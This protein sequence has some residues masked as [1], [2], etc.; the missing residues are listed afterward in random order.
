MRSTAALLIALLVGCE[1][2][3]PVDV[4]CTTD[5]QCDDGAFCNGDERCDPEADA[6]DEDGCVLAEAPCG[7]ALCSE[8]T[9]A[10]VADCPDNDGDG[11]AELSCGGDDCDDAN[12]DRAPGLPE[13]CDPDD[14]DE[15]CDPSTVGDTDL[16]RDG[17]ISRECCNG[18]LCGRDCDDADDQRHPSEAETCDGRDNDCDGLVDEGVV[19]VFYADDDGDDYG[20]LETMAACDRPEGFAAVAGDC[21]DEDDRRSPNAIEVCDDVDN[22]CDGLRDEGLLETFYRDADGDGV[23]LIGDTREACAPPSG[24][25]RL[26]G[27]CDDTTSAISPTIAD[28]CNGI[29][30][31]CDG[32][33]DGPGEDVDRDGVASIACGGNDCDDTSARRRPGLEETCDGVDNDCDGGIDEGLLTATYVDADGDGF[34]TDREDLCAVPAGRITVGGDCDDTRSTVHPM[35]AALCDGLDNDCDAGTPAGDDLDG[36]GEIAVGG[37][38]SGGPYAARPR[39][40]CDDTNA[41]RFAAAIEACN[42]IDDDCDAT[43][44]GAEGTSWCNA[45]G[46][47][48]NA[49]ATCTA[50]SCALACTG[51]FLDC[52]AGPGCESDPRTD[53][54]HCSGCGVACATGQYCSAS[55]CRPTRAFASPMPRPADF[56]RVHSA[57][58]I[59][60]AG[61]F[62]GSQNFGVPMTS[63]GGQ[64]IFVGS[65]TTAGAFRWGV[66]IG[67]AGNEAITGFEIDA[68]HNIYLAGRFEGSV[69]FGT[70]GTPIASAGGMDAFIAS[71]TSTG[72]A[73][74]AR[75]YGT[76]SN[77]YIQAMSITGDDA[78]ISLVTQGAINVHGT[79]VGAAA[80]TTHA[81][82]SLRPFAM[83]YG[84]HQ[85]ITVLPPSNY[86]A[87]VYVAPDRSAWVV[88]QW[89]DDLVIGPYTF[90]AL[91][92]GS[93]AF[94][95]RVDSGGVLGA[96]A[97]DN[98]VDQY[99]FHVSGVPDG[100]VVSGQFRSTGRFGGAPLSAVNN[101][102]G[103]IA[104]FRD[105]GAHVFSVSTPTCFGTRVEPSGDILAWG[106][107]AASGQH[108]LWVGMYNAASGAER[109][110][111]NFPGTGY[112]YAADIVISGTR[113][114]GVGGFDSGG[115]S[116][117][118][119]FNLSSQPGGFRGHLFALDL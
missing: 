5:A 95:A 103:V 118:G 119:V 23:G 22:D 39:T 27:D 13:L 110:R 73:R 84:W 65:F 3:P 25:V 115:S 63:A 116:P 1:S 64:D 76:A 99:L 85:P 93:N 9:D 86:V 47:N 7:G 40:D 100:V 30:D 51:G 113:A 46:R 75:T 88:G 55:T 32:V 111:T 69:A 34:G 16:D 82:V 17:A 12:P 53:A 94:L 20:T 89:R 71:L 91:H 50:G 49:T 41:L 83:T 78:V 67:G 117:S 62:T 61:V 37:A 106:G 11:S 18:P 14:V 58:Y 66:R 79:T 72:A 33:L 2:P 97:F 54:A 21:D 98:G 26:A 77:D 36:D 109:W 102:T 15:D 68:S 112:G 44:D 107:G 6:A 114:Y 60:I 38:C 105:D 56:I 52:T 59:Y 29:D 108:P 81:I 104:R 31:D 96:W 8:I 92:T 90:R 42:G 10:C 45:A 80:A 28:R 70:G 24:Y 101:I 48:P 74:W 35:A 87:D 4:S 57:G 19:D 43:I